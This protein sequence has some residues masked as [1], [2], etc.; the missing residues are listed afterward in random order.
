M[1]SGF[2]L[3]QTSWSP[4]ASAKR[5][6][7]HPIDGCKLSLLTYFE[8]NDP[9]LPIYQVLFKSVLWTTHGD[10]CGNFLKVAKGEVE[11]PF[12]NEV[13]VGLL[14]RCF[15]FGVA[16]DAE[17]EEE[18]GRCANTTAGFKAFRADVIVATRV[19][20]ITAAEADAD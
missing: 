11:V 9:I 14:G 13:R 2:V 20:C 18:V 4:R 10:T 5:A 19:H 17:L 7:A 3:R 12:K 6:N 16:V 15:G 8:S 1:V